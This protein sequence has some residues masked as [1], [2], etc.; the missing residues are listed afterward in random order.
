MANFQ[1][2]YR[3]KKSAKIHKITIQANSVQEAQEKLEKAIDFVDESYD[4]AVTTV[5]PWML[6]DGWGMS[7][8]CEK[9]ILYGRKAPCW[10][11]A[12]CHG[13]TN[14]CTCKKCEKKYKKKLA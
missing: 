9:C 4:R 5:E 7:V 14:G 11:K 8:G 12:Q 2:T 10:G 3:T 13:F 1:L 6:W